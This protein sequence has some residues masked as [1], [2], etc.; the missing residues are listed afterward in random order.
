MHRSIDKNAALS[1]HSHLCLFGLTAIGTALWCFV[2]GKALFISIT[3]DEA[4][5]WFH[6]QGSQFFKCLWDANCWRSAN[7]HLLNTLLWQ[8]TTHWLGANEI[9]MRLPNVLAHLVFLGSSGFLVWQLGQRLWPS[10]AAFLLLNGNPFLLD[11]FALARGYGLCAAFVMLA[12]AFWY[13]YW[14]RER[15]SW[16]MATC[17]AL[18]LAVLSNFVALNVFVA[19]AGVTLAINLR[20]DRKWQWRSAQVW[21]GATLLLAFMLHRPIRFL[22]AA[23]EFQYGTNNLWESLETFVKN[24]LYSNQYLG[25]AT[26]PVAMAATFGAFLLSCV[27][28]IRR[29]WHNHTEGAARFGLATC[30]AF[31][32][33]IVAMIIQHYGLGSVYLFN[34]TATPLMPLLAMALAAGLLLLDARKAWVSVLSIVVFILVGW[35]LLRSANLRSCREWW[36]DENTKSV[37]LYMNDLGNARQQP[38]RLGVSWLFFPAGEFYRT[39]IP[40]PFVEPLPNP[41]TIDAASGHEYYYIEESQKSQLESVYTQEKYYPWGRVLMRKINSE[42][43]IPAQ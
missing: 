19:L 36:Y 29:W 22:Q 41:P 5:T 40:L 4:S 27:F 20:S 33:G 21:G 3:H 24:P 18:V 7:N 8:Q 35:N 25:A 32:A 9:G 10:L 37:M 43:Q 11:F 12:L 23:G 31:G 16:L 14:T 13:L 2:W 38:V 6:H 17:A 34:R 28:L 26:M 42:N 39:T 1:F 15:M 30:L